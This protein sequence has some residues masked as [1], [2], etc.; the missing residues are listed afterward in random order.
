V[1]QPRTSRLKSDRRKGRA[2]AR[3]SALRDFRDDDGQEQAFEGLL[4]E[5][6]ARFARIPADQVD[7][8]ITRWLERIGLFLK[9]DRSSIAQADRSGTLYVSHQWARAGLPPNVVGMK[10]NQFVPWLSKKVAIGETVVISRTS[11]IP[12]EATKDLE[13]ARF[14]GIKS[15]IV[16]P[17]RIGGIVVG[18][19]SFSSALQELNWS[20]R[21]IRRLQLV[22]EVYGG[23]IERQRSSSENR[24]LLAEMRQ[25]SSVA[26]MGELT[27]SLA[28]E[29]NQPLGAVLT[30]ARAA[31]R[32]LQGKRPDLKEI[33]EALDD[34]VRDNSR[35]VETIRQLRAL[36]QRGQ[37]HLRPIDV[38]RLFRDVERIARPEAN[39]KG[40]DLRLDIARSNQIV[41]G[42][43]TQ[44][45]QAILN[46]LTNAFDAVCE[47]TEGPR[48]VLLRA[49]SG[50]Q[51]QLI[52]AVC[53]TGKGI[54]ADMMAKLFNPFATTKSNG[55]G[56]GL[57]IVKTIVETHGGRVWADR[58]AVRGATVQFSLP[59][60][61]GAGS[62]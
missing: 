26:T 36:F 41:L 39:F 15:I 55:M 52:I 29:L 4:S 6:S 57:A 7:L 33:G 5:F 45:T 46:M 60:M 50:D 17:F 9:V 27:A 43:R 47:A 31:R 54:D 18:G 38:S 51:K 23:A 34:I 44:L 53:D 49:F 61:Q 8:E 11:E 62:E 40:V 30:N 35:A 13:F 2:N 19:A 25:I 20:P 24:R 21:L 22:A 42:E 58:N 28:H 1:A 59:L 16:I 12:A 10:L 3:A 37:E 14:L 56:M 32:L 48:E